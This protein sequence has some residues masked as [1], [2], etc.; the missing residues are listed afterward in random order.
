MTLQTVIIDLLCLPVVR[1]ERSSVF[2][3]RLAMHFISLR[4]SVCLSELVTDE[5]CKNRCRRQLSRQRSV[6]MSRSTR[7]SALGSIAGQAQTNK[8]IG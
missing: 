5:W 2:S 8:R 1:R 4:L 7:W 3:R 6:V